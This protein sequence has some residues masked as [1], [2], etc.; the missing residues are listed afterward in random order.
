MKEQNTLLTLLLVRLD[1]NHQQTPV[2]G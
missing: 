1:T 2:T